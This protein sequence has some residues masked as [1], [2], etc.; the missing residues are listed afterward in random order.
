MTYDTPDW[1][2]KDHLVTMAMI[3]RPAR[4][5]RI[6]NF[7]VT[8]RVLSIEGESEPVIQFSE[9]VVAPRKRLDQFYNYIGSEI[10]KAAPDINIRV[11]ERRLTSFMTSLLYNCVARFDDEV[12][13]FLDQDL[14][15]AY[16]EEPNDMSLFRVE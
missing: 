3:N 6:R 1:A 2:D 4:V 12:V 15:S 7:K 16:E 11:F 8:V 10:K 5:E 13:D 14:Y 9:P